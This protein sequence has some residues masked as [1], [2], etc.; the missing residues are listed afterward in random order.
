MFK[1]FA[2]ACLLLATAVNAQKKPS[3]DAVDVIADNYV[4]EANAFLNAA[5][6]GMSEAQM[7]AKIDELNGSEIKDFEAAH[8]PETGCV[9]DYITG[10]CAGSSFLA[11]RSRQSPTAAVLRT[12]MSRDMDLNTAPGTEPG[13][14]ERKT[15]APLVWLKL[16]KSSL[17]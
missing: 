4:A 12:F 1:L 7:L 17:A 8:A 5:K 6:S 11:K 13:L 15:Q 14:Y 3:F 10:E 9:R 16:T 2:S